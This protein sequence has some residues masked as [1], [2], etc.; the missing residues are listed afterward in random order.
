MNIELLFMSL[1]LFQ[2][3]L[4]PRIFINEFHHLPEVIP[5]VQQFDTFGSAQNQEVTRNR[6]LF[7]VII[8]SVL[9]T[10]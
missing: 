1:Y 7:F 3:R 5:E 4:N 10:E 8:T 2:H 6:N 9:G